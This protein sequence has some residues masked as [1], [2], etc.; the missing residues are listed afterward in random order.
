MIILWSTSKSE[1]TWNRTN[2]TSASTP[3]LAP[4]PQNTLGAVMKNDYDSWFPGRG[5]QWRGQN[6]CETERGFRLWYRLFFLFFSRKKKKDK[7]CSTA[8][9]AKTDHHHIWIA[10]TTRDKPTKP[11]IFPTFASLLI[12]SSPHLKWMKAVVHILHILDKICCLAVKCLSMHDI[13]RA[14]IPDWK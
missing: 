1:K 14:T 3:I 8:D 7:C 10:V 6:D 5:E 11:T 9:D 12:Q 13:S 2:N 4:A